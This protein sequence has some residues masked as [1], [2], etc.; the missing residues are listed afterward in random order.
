M[1]RKEAKKETPEDEIKH[2][3]KVCVLFYAAWCGFSQSFLPVFEKYEKS[4]PKECMRV[5]VDDEPKLCEKYSI[6]YYPTVILFKK[7]KVY[8]RLDA[9]PGVGLSR[10]Q[11]K[12]LTKEP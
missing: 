8:K 6:E 11:L 1:A 7:G 12:E 3:D 10:T 2:R 9:E 5:I 4:N